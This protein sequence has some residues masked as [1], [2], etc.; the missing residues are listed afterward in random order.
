MPRKYIISE[1]WKRT[2]NLDDI[3]LYNCG[4]N[5]GKKDYIFCYSDINALVEKKVIGLFSSSA[6]LPSGDS[7][8]T[9]SLGLATP[10]V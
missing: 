9:S 2:S 3:S 7:H 1:I 10:I 8:S 5:Y 6:P 4:R